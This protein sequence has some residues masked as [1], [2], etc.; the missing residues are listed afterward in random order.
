MEQA[1]LWFWDGQ[2]LELL[3]ESFSYIRF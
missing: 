1:H 3:E 2:E